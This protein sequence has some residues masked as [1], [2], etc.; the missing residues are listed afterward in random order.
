VSTFVAIDVLTFT[1]HYAQSSPFTLGFFFFFS[2]LCFELRDSRLLGRCFTTGDMS[3]PF[4]FYFLTRVLCFCLKQACTKILLFT[5]LI[6]EKTDV[7]YRPWLVGWDW[8]LLTL[9]LGWLQ[10]MVFPISVSWIAGIIGVGHLSQARVH[11]W[12]HVF[13]GF[14]KC[15][16][17]CVH[18]YSIIKSNLIA[19]KIPCDLP[20]HHFLPLNPGNLWSF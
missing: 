14:C 11:S 1:H 2:V 17:R 7:Y 10:P 19:L 8:I 20:V 13:W 5:S 18:H 12:C 4:L 15:V 9:S 16:I 3:Q 6:A